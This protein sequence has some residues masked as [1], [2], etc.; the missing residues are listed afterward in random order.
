MSTYVWSHVTNLKDKCEQTPQCI[1]SNPEVFRESRDHRGFVLCMKYIICIW[2]KRMPRSVFNK[3]MKKNKEIGAWES[4]ERR[5]LMAPGQ[6]NLRHN[7]IWSGLPETHNTDKCKQ[8]TSV[9]GSA[10]TPGRKRPFM[11]FGHVMICV[12]LLSLV[13]VRLFFLLNCT[14]E[15]LHFKWLKPDWISILFVRFILFSKMSWHDS[16]RFISNHHEL[17]RVPSFN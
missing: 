1:Q 11:W 5:C 10:K 8:S 12:T 14:D 7:E 9:I 3:T 13:Y 17:D 4:A 6:R 2:F 15:R 16:S